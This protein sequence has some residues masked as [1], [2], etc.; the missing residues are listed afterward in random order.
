MKKKILILFIGLYIFNMNANYGLASYI[1]CGGTTIP[2]E[3]TIITRI[4]V[5]LLQ[6]VT[7]IGLIILGSLD[8]IKSITANNES[9]IKKKQQKFVKRLIAAA[10]LF[11][12]TSIVKLVI[13]V[14]AS[15][16][17]GKNI[18]KCFSCMVN[19]SSECGDIVQGP[20][21]SYPEQGDIYVPDEDFTQPELKGDGED[22]E[23]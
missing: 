10:I 3:L 16:S 15:N 7:P 20:D 8:I 23:N 18:S 17:N 19:S 11:L 6:V 2:E 21:S 12:V 22:E 1:D 5:L 13:G 9:D 14:V 4:I